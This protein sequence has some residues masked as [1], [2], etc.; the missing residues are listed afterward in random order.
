M[1]KIV[2]LT[3]VGLICLPASGYAKP[4]TLY[5]Q[6]KSGDIRATPTYLGKLTGSAALGTQMTIKNKKGSWRQVSSAD[7]KLSGWMHA[8]LL[9]K[10][11]V[12][13]VAA[14]GAELAAS[15]GEMASATKGFTPEVEKAYKEKNPKISFEWVDKMEKIKVKDSEL[16]KFLKDGDVKPKEGE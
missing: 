6:V 11:K 14:K 2:M 10:K 9:T 3:L 7:G 12:K 16:A 15:S 4:K 5:V 8:S 1:K 13:M